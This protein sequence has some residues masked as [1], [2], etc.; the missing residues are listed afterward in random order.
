MPVSVVQLSLQFPQKMQV[1]YRR[2]IFLTGGLVSV[3]WICVSALVGQTFTQAPHPMQ[4][5]GSNSGLPLYFCGTTQGS[6]G[7]RVVNRGEKTAVTASFN[8]L[9][10]GKRNFK[11]PYLVVSI[12]SV[13]LPAADTTGSFYQPALHI[14]QRHCLPT[15]AHLRHKHLWRLRVQRWAK[16]SI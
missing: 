7:N 6:A 8:S 12:R 9:S 2:V 15:T 4:V 3:S 16:L 5:S 13:V 14:C 1:S 10:F 11:L